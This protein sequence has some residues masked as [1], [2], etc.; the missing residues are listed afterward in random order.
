MPT[1]HVIDPLLKGDGGHYLSQHNALWHLCQ[2]Y[3]LSMASYGSTSLNPEVMP[4]GVT[5]S[6]LFGRT[7]IPD[8][9]GHFCAELGTTNLQCYADL[10]DLTAAAFGPDDILFLT[11][12]S[13]QTAIA[14]GQWLRREAAALPCP[15]G[16]YCVVSSELDDTLGRAIRREGMRID[17]SSFQSLDGVIVPNDVKRSIYR[18]LFDAIPPERRGE[19]VIFHE[20][21]FPTRTFLDLAGNDLRFVHLHSMYSGGEPEV[22]NHATPA[23]RHIVFLGSGGV[24]SHEKGGHLV[25]A[26]I[27][28]LLE[29]RGD[30]RFSAQFS[31]HADKAIND[32]LCQAAQRLE[33]FDRVSLFTRGLDCATYCQIIESADLVVLPYGPRYRHFM[34]GVF[35]DCLFLGTVAIIPRDSKMARWMDFHN[36]D[37]PTFDEATTP[38][39]ITAIEAALDQFGYYQGQFHQARRITRAAWHR[40]NPLHCLLQTRTPSSRPEGRFTRRIPC[41]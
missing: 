1:L 4:P 27:P 5:V 13:A 35:D 40:N 14:Y 36:L 32:E 12:V 30:V 39:I 8:M 38:A 16:L 23:C 10:R 11:S 34:S 6:P 7:S 24:A 19:Y 29:R 9:P 15:V 28:P 41:P 26:I 20:E 37:A 21:P 22:S 2:R 18:Y 25:P 17:D 33:G 31:D 3:G